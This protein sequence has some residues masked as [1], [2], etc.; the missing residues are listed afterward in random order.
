MTLSMQ[1]VETDSMRVLLQRSSMLPCSVTPSVLNADLLGGAS[2]VLHVAGVLHSL[3][4]IG[5]L[6]EQCSAA[7]DAV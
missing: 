3:C 2:G 4:R 6:L 5:G 7:S 1:G